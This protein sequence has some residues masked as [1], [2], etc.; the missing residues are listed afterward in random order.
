[1]TYNIRTAGIVLVIAAVIIFFVFDA[2]K[3]FIM[4]KEP[5]DITNIEVDEMK[6]NMHVMTDVYAVW[7]MIITET[8]ENKTYGVTTSSYESSRYYAIPYLYATEQDGE[9]VAAAYSDYFMLVKVDASY[10]S[11]ME[12]LWEATND[13]YTEW[14]EAYESDDTLPESPE[15]AFTLEGYTKK[16][17]KEESSIMQDY[18]EEMGYELDDEHPT[19]ESFYD[20]YYVECFAFSKE[21]ME[22]VFFGSIVLFLL[23]VIVIIYAHNRG[24]HEKEEAAMQYRPSQNYTDVTAQN[25]TFNNS[26][27]DVTNTDSTQPSGLLNGE[28]GVGFDDFI[29]E[30]RQEDQNGE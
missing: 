30:Y 6:K 23:G 19:W 2:N 8:T 10:F 7:D 21:T 26:F 5:V 9:E 14:W 4:H 3:L 20:P 1:M 12:N 16:F 27:S 24:K 25:V 28:S 15:V 11:K 17:D 13:W 18:L 29:S 22:R